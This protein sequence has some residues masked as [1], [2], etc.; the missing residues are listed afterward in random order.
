MLILAGVLLVSG[1]NAKSVE[2]AECYPGGPTIHLSD[3]NWNDAFGA[4]P[5]NYF[6]NWE[7][8]ADTTQAY[9]AFVLPS[10]PAVGETATWSCFGKTCSATR[11][12]CTQNANCETYGAGKRYCNIS[13]GKCVATPEEA[14]YPDNTGQDAQCGRFAGNSLGCR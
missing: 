4:T 2:G 8:Y 9:S 6:C 13:N 7:F 1:I 10:F 3:R 5:K 11:V 12:G 14:G